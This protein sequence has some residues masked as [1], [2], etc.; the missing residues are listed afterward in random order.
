MEVKNLSIGHEGKGETRTDGYRDA[1]DGLFRRLPRVPSL[2]LA[3]LKLT[4]GLDSAPCRD[5]FWGT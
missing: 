3:P 1:A 4:P 5:T 2:P